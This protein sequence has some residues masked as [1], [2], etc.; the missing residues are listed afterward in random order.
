MFHLF[1]FL[2]RSSR[3]RRNRCFG[4]STFV[5]ITSAKKNSSQSISNMLLI[6]SHFI[7]SFRYNRLH[8][9]HLLL[10]F[11]CCFVSIYIYFIYLHIQFY[12]VL[13]VFSNKYIPVFC[14]MKLIYFCVHWNQSTCSFFFGFISQQ[15]VK[16]RE[17][18]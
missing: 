2:F 16:K 6:S 3:N 11:W 8:I 14:Q 1:F 13:Y 5:F 9:Y 15:V 7:L 18:M 10:F 12:F 17:F 4:H